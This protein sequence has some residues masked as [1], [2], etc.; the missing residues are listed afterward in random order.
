MNRTLWI[1]LGVTGLVLA[2]GAAY[3]MG[4]HGPRRMIEARI[5]DAE[6]Y[7]DATPQQRQVIEQAKENIFAA[8]KSHR[9]PEHGKL[10]DILA[11][12]QLDTQALYAFADQRAQDIQ[13][14]AKVIIPEIKKVHDVLTPA[15]RAKLAAKAKQRQQRFQGG[16]GG[17]PQE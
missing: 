5:A 7:I 12:D 4:H 13:D 15:Q 1:G 9:H 2:A 10:I 11:A 3:A 8:I 14:L 17:P 6:D 16:F